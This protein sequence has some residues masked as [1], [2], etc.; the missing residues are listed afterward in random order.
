MIGHVDQEGRALINISVR[1]SD[2]AAAHEFDTWI[3]TGFNGELVLPQKVI[4]DLALETSGT[5]KA[6]L[7]DGSEVVLRRYVCMVDWF[8]ELRDLEV[9]ANEGE[10]PLLGVGLLLGRDLKISYRDGS[11]SIE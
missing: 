4:D 11:L 3:D 7:A 1:P 9:I 2:I 6:V 5:L 10:F 8:E